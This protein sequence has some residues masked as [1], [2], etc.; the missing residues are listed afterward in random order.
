MTLPLSQDLNPAPAPDTGLSFLVLVLAAAGPP[1]L[2]GLQGFVTLLPAVQK[3]WFCGELEK[4][5]GECLA[6]RVSPWRR[7]CFPCFAASGLPHCPGC[8]LAC[9]QWG[10]AVPTSVPP[11][12]VLDSRLIWVL[13]C[14]PSSL[15]DWREAVEPQVSSVL[16]LLLGGSYA[17]PT[18]VCIDRKLGIRLPFM[19]GFLEEGTGFRMYNISLS[20]ALT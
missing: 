13:S 6:F 19:L 20:C 8:T 16:S 14:E 12:L 3:P 1:V 7:A 5:V 9:E 11:P 2:S 15:M 17:V 4:D 18:F 10:Q